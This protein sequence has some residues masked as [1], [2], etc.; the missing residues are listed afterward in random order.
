MKKLILIAILFS[1]TAYCLSQIGVNTDNP[2][3]LLHID[4][5]SSAA[6][7]NP[8]TGNVSA[9]QAADDVVITNSG[10]VGIGLLSPSTKLD[11]KSSTVGAIKIADGTQGINKVLIS[12]ANGVG[13]WANVSGSWFAVLEGATLP[14]STAYA[15]RQLKS[16]ASEIISNATQG[17]VNKTNGTITIPFTGKYRVNITGHW[18]STRA[19]NNPYSVLPVLYKNGTAVWRPN[20]T[21]YSYGWGLSPCFITVLSFTAG[22]V[23]TVYNNETAATTSNQVTTIN[24][25]VEFLQ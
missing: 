16:F 25:I 20:A 17:A 14:T 1:Q 18:M 13:S 7:T 10:N 19:G 8:S 24:L 11:I 6:T 2:K 15:T 21:G 4:G 9:A 3:T 22:D 5:A 23:L 12:D